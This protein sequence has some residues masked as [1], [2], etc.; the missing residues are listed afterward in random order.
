MLK[1]DGLTM[2]HRDKTLL[3]GV[4]FKVQNGEILTLMGVSGSGKSTLLSWMVGALD[5]AFQACGQLWLNERRCDTLPTEARRIG[6]LFQDALLFDHLSVGQN[7]LLALPASVP[8]QQRRTL[9]EAALDSAGL[10]GFYSRDPSTL[11]GGQRARV[12]LLRSLL[13]Q[14]DA[15]LLDEPFS[16]LDA[17]LRDSFRSWVFAE[18]KQRNIPVILVTHDVADIPADGRCLRLESWG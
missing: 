18:V 15:L 17:A 14:P 12:A 11:S 3:N 16:G 4:D 6:I 1:V 9:A 10:S 7:L 13:A 5:G 8:R 2:T